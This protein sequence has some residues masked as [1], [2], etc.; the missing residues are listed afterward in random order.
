MFAQSG[1][2]SDD[3]ELKVLHE[4]RVS[5]P[6]DERTHATLDVLVG[7]VIGVVQKPFGGIGNEI[8]VEQMQ[9]DP[10]GWRGIF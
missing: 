6:G 9:N 3:P 7:R 8:E 2:N 5:D 4:M 10:G 1:E